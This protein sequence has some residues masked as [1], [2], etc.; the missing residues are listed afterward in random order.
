MLGPTKSRL[1]VV[2]GE[3]VGWLVFRPPGGITCDLALRFQ[4]RKLT[5]AWMTALVVLAAV[6]SLLLARGFLA[7]VRR[8]AGA[9]RALHAAVGAPGRAG[10]HG[11]RCAPA[12]PVVAAAP[13]GRRRYPEQARR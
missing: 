8:L 5:A 4:S 13:A 11:G 7:P 6:V 2:D 3:T 12:Q 9:N 10:G 1:V